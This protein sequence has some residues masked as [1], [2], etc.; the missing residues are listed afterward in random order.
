MLCGIWEEGEW[1]EWSDSI[2]TNHL[3]SILLGKKMPP[4]GFP[5]KGVGLRMEGWL[6]NRW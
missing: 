6:E 5:G 3:K 1:E 4:V 2:T